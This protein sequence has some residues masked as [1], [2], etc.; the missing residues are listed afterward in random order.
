MGVLNFIWLK[1]KLSQKK[2]ANLSKV[3]K[4]AIMHVCLTSETAYNTKKKDF[5]CYFIKKQNKA[6]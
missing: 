1:R 3:A 4:V 2:L 5:S 6:K